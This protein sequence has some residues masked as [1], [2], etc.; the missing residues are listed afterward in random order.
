MAGI[1][2]DA[3]ALIAAD[4]GDQRFWTY[5]KA[6]L[7]V[8]KTIPSAVV[9]QAWRGGRNARM[10]RVI[11]ACDIEGLD[12]KLAKEV[13]KLCGRA[14]TS[15]VVDAAV[16]LGATLRQDD[17]LTSDPDDLRR[18]TS[19]FRHPVRVIAVQDL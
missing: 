1:T 2:L 6:A 19:L 17:V 16:A 13:G 5:W 12:E 9:A 14:R 7:D 8:Q 11:E 15:D 10:A 3:G 18:L 4:K